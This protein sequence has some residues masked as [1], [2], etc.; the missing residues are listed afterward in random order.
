VFI[1]ILIVNKIQ[2]FDTYFKTRD[3]KKKKRRAWS[4]L[5][6]NPPKF[7]GRLKF[8]P[9]PGGIGYAPMK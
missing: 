5:R 8:E 7:G 2:R 3:P 9:D 6:I 4:I 1:V